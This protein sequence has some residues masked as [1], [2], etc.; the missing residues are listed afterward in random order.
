[1]L[2]AAPAGEAEAV[3]REELRRTRPRMVVARTRGGL[4]GQ[5]RDDEAAEAEQQTGRGLANADCTR[6]VANLGAHSL[7]LN[8]R[9]IVWSAL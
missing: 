6:R 4:R 1:M 2:L 3:Y 9:A 5:K 7:E 8:E